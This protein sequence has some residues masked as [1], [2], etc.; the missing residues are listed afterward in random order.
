MPKRD[1]SI[2]QERFDASYSIAG[3]SQGR[4]SGDREVNPTDLRRR[5]VTGG[6]SALTVDMVAHQ[7]PSGMVGKWAKV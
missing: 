5:S 2:Q 7:V 6:D 1:I 3:T 4:C